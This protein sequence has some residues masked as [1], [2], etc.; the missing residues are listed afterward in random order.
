MRKPKSQTR[1]R[2]HVDN[3]SSYIRARTI[4]G[5]SPNNDRSDEKVELEHAK[6][7][8]KDKRQKRRK[9]LLLILLIVAGLFVFAF[10]QSTITIVGVEYSNSAI[11]RAQDEGYLS[12]ANQYLIEHPSERF[13][14]ARRNNSLAEHL[15]ELYPE[16]ANIQIRGGFGVGKLYVEIREP[17]AV[18]K[19]PSE[20]S[21]VDKEGAVFKVNY[22]GDPSIIINDQSGSGMISQR[23]LQF[24]G[25]IISGVESSGIGRVEH[26]VI[27]SGAIR[28]VEIS[29]E[30][31]NYAI[32]IQTD[33]DTDSQVADIVNMVNYLK[34]SDISPK[35]VDVRV[36]N[37]GFWQ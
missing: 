5:Y 6:E 33:R 22:Y 9:V 34:K 37:R 13:S 2:A 3:D 10:S 36:K 1:K 14:W 17:V 15:Q 31:E 11:N 26:V 23:F 19:T 35:Y 12:S 25:K 29:L 7:Q 8:K 30:E 4:S 24:I 20:S 27:P 32:K 28:Y 21:F 16:V 18:W